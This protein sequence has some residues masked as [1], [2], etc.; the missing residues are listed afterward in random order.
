[1][2]STRSLIQTFGRASRNVNGHVILYADKMTDSMKKAI[3][4]TLRR[5]KVQSA[6]NKKHGITPTTIVKN[7]SNILHSIY[8]QDYVEVPSV[9]EDVVPLDKIE[10][11][12]TK[13]RREMLTLA[14]KLEFERAAE[15]RDRISKLEKQLLS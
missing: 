15:L 1:M 5:R 13:L 7:I 8:E 2:R 10:K 9:E 11:T 12:I 3:S 14:K 4:E 6:Y